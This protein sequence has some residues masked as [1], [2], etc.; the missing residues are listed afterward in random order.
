MCKGVN[1]IIADTKKQHYV[2]QC[3]LRHFASTDERI[4]VFDKE[5]MEVRSNQDVLNVAIKN[6]FY[7]LNLFEMY[8]KAEPD[9]QAKIKVELGKL[10]GPDDLE[11]LLYLPATQ[12]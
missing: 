7:D 4:N 5:K 3:Y 1:K 9:E 12:I 11:T 6:H 8:K 2:P 10:L